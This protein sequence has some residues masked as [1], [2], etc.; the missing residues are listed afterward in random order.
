[1][2][3]KHTRKLLHSQAS[4]AEGGEYPYPLVELP[5]AAK[6]AVPMEGIKS[7]SK[8][9]N[10]WGLCAICL[11]SPSSRT[12]YKLALEPQVSFA[13]LST[14]AVMDIRRLRRRSLEIIIHNKDEKVLLS[15]KEKTAQ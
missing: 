10:I 14:P 6:P 3:N 15:K 4:V 1:M 8:R 2:H 5:K 13:S 11:C 9:A 7:S 12:S